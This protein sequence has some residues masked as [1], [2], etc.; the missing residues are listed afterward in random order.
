LSSSPYR[1]GQHIEVRYPLDEDKGVLDEDMPPES[2][3]WLAGRIDAEL[4]EAAEVIWLVR[5]T[6]ERAA[7]EEAGQ[8]W[9]PQVYR[10]ASEIRPRP[11]RPV[12]AVTHADWLRALARLLDEEA[13]GLP[14]QRH[15]R[16]M[17][18]TRADV[19]QLAGA[20]E[21]VAGVWRR[22]RAKSGADSRLAGDMTVEL[23]VPLPGAGN[24]VIKFLAH[25]IGA[26]RATVVTTVAQQRWVLPGDDKPDAL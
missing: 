17:W 21:A 10:D 23:M 1:V 8:T 11:T 4:A 12:A 15:G 2:W 14:V 6:D 19:R 3:P 16:E 9:C 18:V 13:P 24:V 5:V 7:V 20:D 26:T 22:L 25:E